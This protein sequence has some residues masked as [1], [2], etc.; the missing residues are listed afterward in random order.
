METVRCPVC[1]NPIQPTVTQCENGHGVCNNC[2]KRHNFCSVCRGSFLSFRNRL[3]DNILE[4]LP[5]NCSFTGCPE[6]LK[7]GDDHEKWCGFRQTECRRCDWVGRGNKIIQHISYDHRDVAILSESNTDMFWRNI[8]PPRGQFKRITT[9]FAPISAHGHF[10]WM[11]V[12]NDTQNNLFEKSFAFVRNGKKLDKTFVVKLVLRKLANTYTVSSVLTVD[13]LLG[14]DDSECS[15][16][17]HSSTV[18]KFVS[19]DNK[20]NYNLFV[21]EA[22]KQRD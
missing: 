13:S 3:L 21:E 20:L 18:V 11:K 2:R 6:I 22:G 15:I 1:F 17:L 4:L 5:H 14:S 7:P 19:S 9:W 12:T 16:N 10:F 8:V